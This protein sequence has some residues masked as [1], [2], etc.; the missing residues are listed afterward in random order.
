MANSKTIRIFD[1]Q[2]KTY[3]KRRKNL[4]L[5]KER[6]KLL[7]HA[8]G[9]VLEVSVGAGNNFPFYPKGVHITA[10]DFSPK[11]IEKAM[12]AAEDYGIK[13]KLL[14]S[15]VESMVF[16]ENEF[17]TIVSTLS[18][19]AYENP[20]EVL[21]K[22]RYWVKPNGSVLL[23]EHGRSANHAFA[24]FQ[25][26]FDGLSVKFIG[27]HQNRDILKMVRNAGIEIS[28]LEMMMMQSV[29]LIHGVVH[30]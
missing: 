19:C 22:M 26:R 21:K 18:L 20:E 13:C 5:A 23:F 24:W 2:A 28:H 6:R 3:D 25:D 1:R 7:K 27:C 17:D 15:D 11:M 14:V 29:F 10:V 4:Q 8:V 16:P 30:K 9:N 12:E